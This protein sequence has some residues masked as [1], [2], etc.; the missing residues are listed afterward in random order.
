MVMATTEPDGSRTERMYPDLE[1][2]WPRLLYH[3][4]FMLA[5]FLNEIH[6]PP[7]P[8]P[9]LAANDPEGA[10]QWMRSRA[11][12]EHVRQSIVDHLH[13][14]SSGKPVAIRRIEHLIPDFIEF[15]SEGIALNDQRYYRVLL[16]RPVNTPNSASPEELPV[17]RPET[18]PPPPGESP[19]AEELAETSP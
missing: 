17:G 13:S 19:G 6:Q 1:Q 5:E 10:D 15:G 18:I 14:K 8:P 7:G 2:H 11:Q 3:R 12:Y 16:D 4:H 9:D